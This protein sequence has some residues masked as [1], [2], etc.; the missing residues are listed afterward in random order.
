MGAVEELAGVIR[1]RIRAA[2]ERITFAEYMDLALY[3]PTYGYYSAGRV[4]LGR[5]GDFT[6][7]PEVDPAFGALLAE[8][9]RRCDEKLGHPA[10]FLLA[11]HGGGS[12]RLMRDM[13]DALRETQPALY[14]RADAVLVERSEALR[15]RQQ[16]LLA[17]AGHDRARW[18]DAAV[19]TGLVLS[20]ELLDAFAVHR[21]LAEEDG[22]REIY[23]EVDADGRFVETIGPPSDPALAAYFE[24]ATVTPPDRP[25]EVNLAAPAW[26]RSVASDLE[27]GFVLTIDYGDSAAR[28]YSDLRPE[29]TLLC[30]SNGRVTD[31]PYGAPGTQD[32]TAH[33]DFTTL[34][35]VG[36]AAGLQTVVATR[37][38]EFLVDL[39]IG[40]RIAALS[41]TPPESREAA[42][43]MLAQRAHLFRLIDPDGLGRFHVLVMLKC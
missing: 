3:H 32:M 34:E 30:Y 24:D 29:G 40:E 15:S 28:L 16:A 41:A 5:G 13:L 8:F 20:N 6:T 33:V 10:R 31:D 7:S 42:R 11:E 27:R 14:S 38:M 17:E 35:R 25:C 22:L 1:E 36:R 43:E 39:G 12:G 23:V 9:A 26:L 2:G 18:A 21:L 4:A 19:G 37:Q